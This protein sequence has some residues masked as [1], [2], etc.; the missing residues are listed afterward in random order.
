MSCEL[1]GV[2]RG[3]GQPL[4]SPGQDN[5][6]TICLDYLASRC[7]TNL[8]LFQRLGAIISA[9][10]QGWMYYKH[11]SRI[12]VWYK[13]MMGIDLVRLNIRD[14]ADGFISKPVINV[15]DHSAELSK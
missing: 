4:G 15:V 10:N 1:S 7:D 11:T 14:P 2:H 6:L 13:M 9:I 5:Q 3:V 12:K 8:Q